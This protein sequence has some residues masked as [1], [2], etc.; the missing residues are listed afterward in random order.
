MAQTQG[1]HALLG[2]H[3][4]CLICWFARRALLALFVASCAWRI[5]ISAEPDATGSKKKRAGS[6]PLPQ[7]ALIDSHVRSQWQSAG[8]SP[9]QPAT[10]GE[11]CRRAYLDVLGR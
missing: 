10:E 11:W 2:R 1:S 7:V 8:I 5:A 9:S 4:T 6:P 3:S